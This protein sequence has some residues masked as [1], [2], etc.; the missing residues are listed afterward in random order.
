MSVMSSFPFA[1]LVRFCGESIT[2]KSQ[3]FVVYYSLVCLSDDSMCFG[4]CKMS[5]RFSI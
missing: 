3:Y 4:N 5:S 2:V 1:S